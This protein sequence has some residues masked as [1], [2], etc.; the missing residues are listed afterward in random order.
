MTR[1]TAAGAIQ[2]DTI[3]AMLAADPEGGTLHAYSCGCFNCS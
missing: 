3:T 1:F 2:T